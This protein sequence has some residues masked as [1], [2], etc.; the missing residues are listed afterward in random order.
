MPSYLG[1]VSLR[2]SQGSGVSL[3]AP[4]FRIFLA[5]GA[6]DGSEDVSAGFRLA[7]VAGTTAC[8]CLCTHLRFI[9]RRDEDYWGGILDRR[10]SPAQIQPGHPIEL[11]VEY[12][13]I[14][15]RMLRVREERFCGWIGD[16]INVSG[17]QEPAHRLANA[18]VIINN[19]DIDVW[20]AAH[21]TRVAAGTLG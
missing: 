1:I 15:L 17:P 8:L 7:E 16:R 9:V 11:D 14:K 5:D 18:L 4:G 3:L 20:A 19:R 10:E 21:K 6:T 2:R 13:T 12:Q